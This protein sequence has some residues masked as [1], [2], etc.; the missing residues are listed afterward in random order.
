M[1]PIVHPHTT[2]YCSSFHCTNKPHDLWYV[3][4]IFLTFLYLPLLSAQQYILFHH[5]LNILHRGCFLGL[6]F[7][8]CPLPHTCTSMV[9]KFSK[10]NIFGRSPKALIVRLRRVWLVIIQLHV[11]HFDVHDIFAT[12]SLYSF[13]DCAHLPDV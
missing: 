3:Y 9:V 11:E 10:L 7:L 8:E 6:K 13:T 5:F 4:F 12:F 1:V 2:S